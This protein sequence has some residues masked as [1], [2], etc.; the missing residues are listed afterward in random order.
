[1][2][3]GCKGKKAVSPAQ[4]PG[5]RSSK[6]IFVEN[7]EIRTSTPPPSPAVPLQDVEKIVDK[8]NEILTP[9]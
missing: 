2:G 3:C 5:Q 9:Q 1:M 4:Q 8:L 7:G 6:I